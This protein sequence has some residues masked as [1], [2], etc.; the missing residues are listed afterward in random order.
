LKTLRL[1]GHVPILIVDDEPFIALALAA[2]VQDA[3][4][5]IVGPAATVKEALALLDVQPLAAAILDV[6]LS[7]G[8]IGPVAELLIARGVPIFF[9]TAVGLSDELGARFPNV[10]VHLKPLSPE[11]LVRE[12]AAMVEPKP[13]SAIDGG[14]KIAAARR[15]KQAPGC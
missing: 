14:D 4:G 8:D 15:V 12:L 13:Q 3:G 11:D 5:S 10:V 2:N 9:H 7:D 6:N 1:L